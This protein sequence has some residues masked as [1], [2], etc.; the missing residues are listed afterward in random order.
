MKA[1]G[2]RLRQA[3]E[4]KGVSV[5]AVADST[6]ISERY[7]HALERGDLEE[8]P[9]GVF[10]KGYIKSYAELLDIDPRPLLESYGIEERKRGLGTPEHERQELTRLTQLADN[11]SS[12]RRGR[13]ALDPA[14]FLVALL[15]VALVGL[16]AAT[17]WLIFRGRT[18]AAAPTPLSEDSATLTR[19]LSTGE[20]SPAAPRE[21]PVAVREPAPATPN[22][23]SISQAGVGTGVVERSLVGRNDRFPEGAQVWFWTRIVGGKSGDR[24]FHVWIHEG[25]THMNAEL[26]VGGSHWRTYSTLELPAGTVGEWVV[27]V[28]AA[29]GTVL[30]QEKFLCVSSDDGA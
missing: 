13:A 10:D 6:R 30:A 26:R 19:S 27:E 12:V 5:R 23:L 18:P 2:D 7:L 22:Q 11:R 28:R 25:R 15:G 17:A 9:G 20:T 16:V 14:R 1:F 4:A 3:R 8:L 29:N 24:V 21:E